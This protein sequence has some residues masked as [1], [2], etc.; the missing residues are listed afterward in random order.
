MDVGSSIRAQVMDFADSANPYLSHM[1]VP[2]DAGN[3]W[4]N[5]HR[6]EIKRN[7]E[8]L[9]LVYK[10][11]L[12]CFLVPTVTPTVAWNN[13]KR[14]P[15]SN[16]AI[17]SQDSFPELDSTSQHSTWLAYPQR[18]SIDVTWLVWRKALWICIWLWH[19]PTIF[20]TYEILQ[21]KFTLLL[22]KSW[23]R[24]IQMLVPD[25]LSEHVG[26]RDRR[27]AAAPLNEAGSQCMSYETCLYMFVSYG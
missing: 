5:K 26:F 16:P 24:C 9:F 6:V 4:K 23:K 18:M 7:T 3:S 13:L 20:L 2:L 1:D 27:A 19:Q 22:R 17:P 12:L 8:S 25:H 14:L 21:G 11:C 10:T 15:D